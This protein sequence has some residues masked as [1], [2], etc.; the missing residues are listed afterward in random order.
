MRTLAAIAIVVAIG[1]L[2]GWCAWLTV[3]LKRAIARAERM[4]EQLWDLRHD[5]GQ[6]GEGHIEVQERVAEIDDLLSL[7]RGRG[8]K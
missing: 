7:P 6:L 3:D 2:T 8:G 5:L 1:A 4:Q